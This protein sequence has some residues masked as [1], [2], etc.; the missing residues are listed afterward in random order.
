MIEWFQSM[1]YFFYN[2]SLSFLDVVVLI[3]IIHLGGFWFL[4]MIPWLWYSARK[5]IQYS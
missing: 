5:K 4:T 2:P 1:L 3:A